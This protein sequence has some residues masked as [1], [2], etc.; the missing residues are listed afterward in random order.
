MQYEIIDK[1]TTLAGTKGSVLTRMQK[2]Y[3]ARDG[4][5]VI[6]NFITPDICDFL[7]QRMATLINEFD[8]GPM[9]SI[10]SSKNIE[11]SKQQYFLESGDKIHFFFEEDAFDDD[12]TLLTKKELCINK[13]G[14]ALHELDATFY[15]F[16]HQHRIAVLLQDLGITDPKIVQS[17]YICKQP[18]FGGEVTCH[19]DSTYLFVKEQPITGLWIALENATVTNGCLWAIPGG[20]QIPLKSR[21]FRDKNNHVYTQVYDDT[22]WPLEK[23]IPLEVPRGSLIVLHGLLPHMSKINMSD[24]SRHAYTLHAISGKHEFS[25]DNWLRREEDNPFKTML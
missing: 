10:F 13:V 16:S 9:K 23:M 11:H 19:Q 17:M 12:G 21:M 1:D 18:H 15:C 25:H 6:K 22:A 7:M 14:H 4:F 20:H 3:Y 8:P 24:H 2:D 5:L